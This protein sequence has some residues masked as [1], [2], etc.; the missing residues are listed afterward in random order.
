MKF[1]IVITTYNRL[2][3]LKRA[4]GSALAQTTPCEVVVVDN[5]STD[6]TEAYVRSLGEQ[7]VYHRNTS[8]LGH[9]GAVNAGVEAAQ[10]DWIKL[11]DDDDY[12][13]PT[14]VETMLGAIALRPQAVI[15]SCQAAQVDTN[16]VEL[17]RTRKNGPGQAFYIPQMDIHYGM[18]MEVVP[19]GT[20]IQVAVRRDALLKSGGWDL[21]MTSCD[22][23]DSWIR[24]A[25]FGDAVFINQCL[26][27]RTVWPGG[28]DQKMSFQ[29]RMETN[30]LIKE[31]IH[32]RVDAQYRASIPALQHIRDY[33]HLYWGVVALK[34]KR[35]LPALKLALPG[36][37]S[38]AAWK[39]LAATL[40]SR[41]Q[42][43]EN[44]HVRK[45]VL[46]P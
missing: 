33:L 2:S 38:L 26:T 4:I 24:I 41:Q 25:Q 34:Q 9:S 29:Q 12:L 19:F 46:I 39:L 5:A 14:C 22:D 18:L 7:V 30:A 1:S 3:L 20:P 8:N 37:G 40:S 45:L 32:A 42:Q 10:G 15:C 13:A 43:G 28:Y 6:G 31:R 36:I 16:E 11:V 17:S 35:L 23:I 44:T 27:Y 21:S